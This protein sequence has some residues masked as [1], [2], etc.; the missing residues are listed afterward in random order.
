MF[1]VWFVKVKL[2]FFLVEVY[3]RGVNPSV[4]SKSDRKKERPSRTILLWGK[5]IFYPVQ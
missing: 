5:P 1:D 3:I 4:V 2:H